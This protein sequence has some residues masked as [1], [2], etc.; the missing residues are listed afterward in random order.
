MMTLSEMKNSLN[1]L[2]RS[3]EVAEKRRSEHKEKLI[4]YIHTKT[5]RKRLKQKRFVNNSQFAYKWNIRNGAEG[6]RGQKNI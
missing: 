1:S 3:L 4:D 5:Q 6:E 2:S